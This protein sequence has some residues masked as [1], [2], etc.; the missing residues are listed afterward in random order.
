MYSINDDYLDNQ[1]FGC[2]GSIFVAHCC[3][4]HHGPHF[5]LS[6]L[7]AFF[8]QFPHQI[9]TSWCIQNCLSSHYIY[10]WLK[11][12]RYKSIY[13]LYWYILF[14]CIVFRSDCVLHGHSILVVQPIS[15]VSMLSHF[16]PKTSDR[17]FDLRCFFIPDNSPYPQLFE[18]GLESLHALQAQSSNNKYVIWGDNLKWYHMIFFV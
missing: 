9:R 18:Q 1:Y 5:V 16:P 17:N 2:T 7:T 10:S 14:W 4:F 15:L 8:C 13:D 12:D 3:M 11:K 6:S